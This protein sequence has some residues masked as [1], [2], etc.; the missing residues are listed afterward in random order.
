MYICRLGWKLIFV[1]Y[2]YQKIFQAIFSSVSGSSFHRFPVCWRVVCTLIKLS[3]RTFLRIGVSKKKSSQTWKVPKL[4]DCKTVGFF[5]KISKEISKAW[6][7]S[8]TC[9]KCASLEARGKYGLFCSLQN[10][11]LPPSVFFE[12]CWLVQCK[13]SD[14]K[15]LDHSWHCF[16]RQQ[17]LCNT[18]SLYPD[19]NIIRYWQSIVVMLWITLRWTCILAKGG[20]NTLRWSIPL[21]EAGLKMVRWSFLSDIFSEFKELWWPWQD[22]KYA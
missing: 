4:L 16:C 7:K 17:T 18:T 20:G 2:K 8:L 5:L 3:G 13:I 22:N 10:Y 12:W 14:H 11:H 15:S 6:R 19:M 21:T 9:A 1:K